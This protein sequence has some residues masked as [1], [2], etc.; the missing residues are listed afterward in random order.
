MDGAS[1]GSL[2]TTSVTAETGTLAD[3]ST[4]KTGKYVVNLNLTDNLADGGSLTDTV[5]VSSQSG[6]IT[7]G[8]TV[9]TGDIYRFTVDGYPV[10]YTVTTEVTTSQGLATAFANA[11]NENED[12]KEFYLGLSTSGR[13]SFREVKHYRRRKRWL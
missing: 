11:I 2:G 7:L 9:E 10:G 1:D 12:V 13:K 3:G 4:G 8:G 6:K 5:M